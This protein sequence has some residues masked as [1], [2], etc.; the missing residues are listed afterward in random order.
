MGQI[1]ATPRPGIG[2]GRGASCLGTKTS[3][4]GAWSL[5]LRR[6]QR[7]GWP[8]EEMPQ[9]LN[10]QVTVMMKIVEQAVEGDTEEPILKAKA[11]T[12]FSL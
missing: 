5:Q 8:V 11:L 2:L 9:V 7:L 1:P 6:L 12:D 3:Q 10:F 4:R